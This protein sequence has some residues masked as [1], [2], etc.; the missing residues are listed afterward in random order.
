MNSRVKVENEVYFILDIRY[1]SAVIVFKFLQR[2]TS[3]RLHSY[4]PLA[5]E[6][7]HEEEHEHEDEDKAI[8]NAFGG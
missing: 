2:T 8:T 6:E 1:Y 3:T 5:M 7:E 4:G